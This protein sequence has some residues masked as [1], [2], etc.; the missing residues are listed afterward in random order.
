MSVRASGAKRA[1][2]GPWHYLKG[3]DGVG[4]V[5]ELILQSCAGTGENLSELRCTEQTRSPVNEV[6][7]CQR[8]FCSA[9]TVWL[10]LIWTL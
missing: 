3:K 2:E 6:A 7:F 5:A 10:H 1:K 8:D 9:E 4:T